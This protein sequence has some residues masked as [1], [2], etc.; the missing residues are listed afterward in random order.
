MTRC[1][2]SMRQ[3]TNHLQGKKIHSMIPQSGTARD[4]KGQE[5]AFWISLNFGR[6]EPFTSMNT[7]GKIIFVSILCEN[8][9]VGSKFIDGLVS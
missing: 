5:S 6:G 2:F 4:L 3:Q 1:R 7:L 8:V 9:K